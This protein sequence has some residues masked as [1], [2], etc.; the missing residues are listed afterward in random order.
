MKPTFIAE[1]KTKSPFGYESNKTWFQ[2]FDIAAKYGDFLSIH[3]SPLWGGS[4]DLLY[5][6]KQK[7]KKP[8]LAKGLHLFKEDIEKAFDYGADYVMTYDQIHNLPF[9]SDKLFC[10]VRNKKSLENL[11]KNRDAYHK[12]YNGIT[13][14]PKIIWNQRDL[15]NGLPKIVDFNE[16]REDFPNEYLCQASMIET[17]EDVD[18]KA[19]AFIVGQNLETFVKTL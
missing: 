7:T 17:I 19:D 9:N 8:I 18:M 15:E 3:T 5:L 2:L 6:A 13:N 4:Y 12:K 10:E 16:I 1:V 14:N 11:L